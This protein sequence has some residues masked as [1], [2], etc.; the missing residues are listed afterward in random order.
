MACAISIATDATV[1]DARD[2]RLIAAAAGEVEVVE[3]RPRVSPGRAVRVRAGEQ[4]VLIG[5]Q[6]PVRRG[7][8]LE[9]GVLHPTRAGPDVSH[10]DRHAAGSGRDPGSAM[11]KARAYSGDSTPVVIWFCQPC[12]ASAARSRDQ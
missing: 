8:A 10:D 3:Q 7:E 6:A 1:G 2:R 12:P 5:V 4:D 9:N 11:T